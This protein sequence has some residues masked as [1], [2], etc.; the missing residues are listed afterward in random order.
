MTIAGKS[1][2]LPW[3]FYI[4]DNEWVSKPLVAKYDKLLADGSPQST[5]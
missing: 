3:R 1:A 2:L 5:A 4:E